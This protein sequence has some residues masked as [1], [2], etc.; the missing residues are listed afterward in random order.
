[1]IYVVSGEIPKISYFT[2]IDVGV[3]SSV[4]VIFLIGVGNVVCQNLIKNDISNHTVNMTNQILGIVLVIWYGMRNGMLLASEFWRMS[5][6]TKELD[7]DIVCC[8]KKVWDWYYH[9]L[10]EYCEVI[11]AAKQFFGIHCWWGRQ[12]FQIFK[13]NSQNFDDQLQ[14]QHLQYMHADMDLRQSSYKHNNTRLAWMPIH[15]HENDPLE[16]PYFRFPVL[17]EE[18]RTAAAEDSPEPHREFNVDFY[19]ALMQ[20]NAGRWRWRNFEGRRSGNLCGAWSRRAI[21][22]RAAPTDI[23]SSEESTRLLTIQ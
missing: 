3:S 17:D 2:A 1:M 15:F 16:H 22:Y 10:K 18:D 19:V 13:S 7:Y 4:A 5:R 21:A 6:R 9:F 14:N 11:L 8:D 20:D 12:A 23:D